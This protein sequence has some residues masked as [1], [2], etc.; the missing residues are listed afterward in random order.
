V[1]LLLATSSALVQAQDEEPI[2]ETLNEEGYCTNPQ[3]DTQGTTWERDYAFDG[4]DI[5]SFKTSLTWTDDESGIA[6]VPDTFRLI[7]GDAS[8]NEGVEEGSSGALE[9]GLDGEALDSNW[10]ITVQCLE[11]G[12]PQGPLG[13]IGDAGNAWNLEIVYTYLPEVEEPAEPMGPPQA[14][15]DLYEDPIFWIHVIFMIASTY[16]FGL[17]GILAAVKLIKGRKWADDPSWWKAGLATNRPFRA[18]ATHAWM[19]FF[20]AAIPLGMYVAGKAYGWENMWTSLPVV[21]NAWFYQWDN[22]D[23]VSL[24]VLVLWAIPLW[25]NRQQL[26]ASA[27][28]YWFFGRFGWFKRFAAK[29]PEPR[30][31]DREL[32]LIYFFMGVLIFL[33][34]M[35]QPHGN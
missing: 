26:M 7:V 23:H 4:K 2:T 11:A 22:A 34:F 27:P 24:I 21:W 33:L 16:M 20:I 25:L 19:V 28:H 13:L 32:A 12:R 35:V 15:Q 31:S 9:V 6:S 17:V 8:G 30:I 10:T 3:V 5:I 1:F 18:L 29:A 14:I